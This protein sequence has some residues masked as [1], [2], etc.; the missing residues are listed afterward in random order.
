MATPVASRLL[1]IAAPVAVVAVVISGASAVSR[2]AEPSD[3]AAGGETAGVAAADNELQRDRVLGASRSQSAPRTSLTKRPAVNAAA[4]GQVR[5][6]EP[7]VVASKYTTTELNV[8]TGP[9]ERFTFLSVLD[10]GNKVA[11]TKYHNGPWAQ[12]VQNG[13][14]HWVRAA[15]LSNQQ[16]EPEPEPVEEESA[17]AGVTGI[18]AAPCA[19]GSSVESGLTADAVRVHRAVCARYPEVSGYGGVRYDGEH[20]EG[21]ALDIMISGSSGDSL[22]EWVRAN[23]SALGVSEVLWAQQIWTV[24]RSSEGWRPFEDRGSDTANHYDHVHVT[25]YGNS[26]S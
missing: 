26:G 2:D 15:Y 10:S 14:A 7:K 13:Q 24:Q 5:E 25:V 23:S 6:I 8:W 20:G 3:A 1:R 19:S 22:A 21:R 12:I 11:V 17:E 4:S 9:G 16:P 18:S